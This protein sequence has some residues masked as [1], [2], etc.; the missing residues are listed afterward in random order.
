MY[1]TYFDDTGSTG[2]NYSDLQQPI[3]G[4]CSISIHHNKLGDVE[5]SYRQIVDKYF[6]D[7]SDSFLNVKGFEFHAANIIHADSNSIFRSKTLGERQNLLMDIV[8]IVVGHSLPVLGVFAK[9]QQASDILKWYGIPRNL[10]ETLFSS[11]FRGL[12]T[13]LG[14]LTP[15]QCAMLIG[16]HDSVKPGRAE[17]F[18]RML[19]EDEVGKLIQSIKFDK[20]YLS[21]GIQLADI[22]AYLLQRKLMHPE[23]ENA[24]ADCI[25]HALDIHLDPRHLS[26]IK[27]N[28]E[29]GILAF[30][31]GW[32]SGE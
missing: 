5:R 28:P 14:S 30:R 26:T 23:Q 16:D 21:F 12:A 7:N 17:D 10:D 18:K 31:K 25:L 9:K 32:V 19:S 13:V 2:T 24:A 8:N 1:H 15:P 11:L 4:L 3:Q 20:S 27:I 29:I 6:P 22:V